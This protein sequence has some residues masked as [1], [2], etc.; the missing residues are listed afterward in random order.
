MKRLILKAIS[1]SLIV[2]FSI[3]NMLQYA[4][5]YQDTLRPP[6]T[7]LTDGPG[8]RSSAAG[9]NSQAQPTEENSSPETRTRELTSR[10]RDAF[11]DSIM[12][13]DTS[14]VRARLIPIFQEIIRTGASRKL[15][16]ACASDENFADLAFIEYVYSLG[17]RPRMPQNGIA[18][19]ISP[20][21]LKDGILQE[22]QEGSGCFIV[23][24]GKEIGAPW[25]GV[26][27]KRFAFWFKDSSG[28]ILMFNEVENIL[29]R[30]D[31][32]LAEV[33]RRI[34]LKRIRSQEGV[35]KFT[36]ILVAEKI[37]QELDSGREILVA[38]LDLVIEEGSFDTF[39]RRVEEET[40]ILA[41]EQRR[42]WWSDAVSKLVRMVSFRRQGPE[43][44]A[45]YEKCMRNFLDGAVALLRRKVKEK[46]GEAYLRL[47][48]TGMA[49]AAGDRLCPHYQTFFVARDLGMV[50]TTPVP[51]VGRFLREVGIETVE[52]REGYA[53]HTPPALAIR[54]NKPF[55]EKG[56]PVKK[57]ELFVFVL[58]RK[59][60]N[61][62]VRVQD[63]VYQ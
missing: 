14:K 32:D 19:V 18:S 2:T 52:A 31:E 44:R 36:T 63:R 40:R 16:I 33:S 26:A 45:E 60:V 11:S 7:A 4:Y 30:T 27:K 35:R 29:G 56:A 38:G 62:V 22:R 20:K 55:M 34:K 48:D 54:P 42:S 15:G 43:A 17:F 23:T 59:G 53:E 57:A 58:S 21:N 13:D 41:R 24:L 28:R 12:L 5:S 46:T 6:S 39:R 61:N 8:A 10:L 49:L 47:I 37:R 1:Y 51:E 50:P 9:R 3:N 25:Q